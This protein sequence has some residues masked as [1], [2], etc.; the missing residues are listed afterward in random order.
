MNR[1]MTDPAAPAK[2]LPIRRS[3]R[4]RIAGF[5]LRVGTVYVGV[6]IVLLFL[7]NA[8]L[9]HPSR[10]MEKPPDGV[11]VED[12]WVTTPDGTRIHGWW[13]PF[14]GARGALLY[15]HGNAGNLSHRGVPALLLRQAVGE[16][17]LLFDY[18]GFGKSD[19]KPSEA[20]CYA[21]GEAMFD[22]LLQNKQIPPENIIIFGK[23]LGGG[24]ATELATH[25]PHRALVL[26]KSFT[27]IPDMA[28]KQFPFLPARWLVTN[29]FDNLEKIGRCPRPVLV[30]HGDQ[31]ELIPFWMGKKL[32]EAANEPKRFVLFPGGGHNT[33]FPDAFYSE[34][35]EFLS[36]AAPLQSAATPSST[37]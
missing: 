35:N 6:I 23:S 28:Q 5:A 10:D 30:A 16:S 24:V 27:S 3:W 1:E 34:L 13:F 20:G 33:P 36:K 19:G 29:R 15:C 26:V 2:A 25:R 32:Y 22:W 12:V 14:P 17:V 4:R 18:P 9:Y 37:R 7:E 21:A 31:D 8:L 11:T